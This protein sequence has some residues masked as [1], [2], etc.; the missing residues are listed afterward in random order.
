MSLLLFEMN[1]DKV[2]AGSPRKDTVSTNEEGW[3][4]KKTHLAR[5][6]TP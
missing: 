2:S 6:E 4:F 3:V 5:C 1:K